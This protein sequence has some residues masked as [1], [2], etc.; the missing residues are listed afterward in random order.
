MNAFVSYM[1]GLFGASAAGITAGWFSRR[2][3]LSGRVA[4]ALL[5]L[6]ACALWAQASEIPALSMIGPLAFFFT[7]PAVALYALF[8]RRG[9]PDRVA[10]L[11]A[12]V[13]GVVVS[14]VFAFL[15]V[16]SVIGL[17]DYFKTGT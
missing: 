1:F 4:L 15:F 8:V 12:F 9:A 14:L 13:G 5:I 16:A 7:A 11:A 10:A 3:P 17:V 2:A 6:P